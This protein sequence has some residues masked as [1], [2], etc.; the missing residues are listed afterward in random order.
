METLQALDEAIIALRV[1]TQRP[2]YRQRL[3]APVPFAGGMASL[4]VM[5]SVE[6]LADHHTKPSIRKVA[7]DLGVEHSTASRA[8]DTLA[9]AGLLTR[10]RCATDQRQAIL[11]LTEEG[12]ATLGAVTTHRQEMLASI[13]EDWDEVELQTLT[14]LLGRLHRAFDEEFG[15]A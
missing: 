7:E 11:Q 5:R 10:T 13:V 6:R 1:A 15:G 4:R 9:R 3:L 8:V 14:R 12:R 2:G